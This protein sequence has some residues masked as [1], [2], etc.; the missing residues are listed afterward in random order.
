KEE[1][2]EITFR[3]EEGPDTDDGQKWRKKYQRRRVKQ[4][5]D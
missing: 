5:L 1:G 2:P 4:V 3:K